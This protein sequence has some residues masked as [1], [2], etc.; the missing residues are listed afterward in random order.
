[1]MAIQAVTRYSSLEKLSSFLFNI[2]FR[3]VIDVSFLLRWSM[4]ELS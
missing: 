2:R 3:V 4:G 1:M